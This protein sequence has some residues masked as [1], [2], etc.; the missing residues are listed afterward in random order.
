M[1]INIKLGST[2][3]DVTTGLEGY[4]IQKVE[5]ID[6]NVQYAVQPQGDGKIMPDA[7][8]ID[9]HT[10]DVIDEGISARASEPIEATIKLGQEVRDTA[11]DFEGV[12]MMRITYINGCIR[13][14]VIPR[15]N[16]KALMQ[17]EVPPTSFIDQGRLKV[18]GDGLMEKDTPQTTEIKEEKKRVTGGPSTRAAR[19]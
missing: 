3:R 18:I 10:L 5:F 17:H 9:H 13:Y 12:A 14:A 2:I 6:G 19:F 15:I 1:N 7:Y 8:N 11:S 4:A 16:K